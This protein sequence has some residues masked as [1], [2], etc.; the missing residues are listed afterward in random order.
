M[1]APIPK[2]LLYAAL[3]INAII[4]F[5]LS[6]T[7][8]AS[9]YILS[10]LGGNKDI[11]SYTTSFFALGNA[12][13]IPL[14][15]HF[16]RSAGMKTAIKGALFFL[17][18]ISFLLAR[19]P[20]Y[21]IFLLL[22]FFQGCAAGPLL[23]LVPSVLTT[24][25]D[26]RKKNFFIR[27]TTVIYVATSIVAACI[28]GSIAYEWDWRWIF[29]LDVIL[30]GALTAYFLYQ[31][32]KVQF[33]SPHKPIDYLG[34]FF[35][36]VGVLS[37]SLFCILGQQ[38]D[39][40]R[41]YR[42]CFVFPIGVISLIYFFLHSYN[43]PYPIVKVK[44]LFKKDVIFVIV[45]TAMLFSAYFG[46]VFLLSIWLNQYVRYTPN[47]ITLVLGIMAVT[48][49]GVM[50]VMHKL[51]EEHL[52]PTLM[53]AIFFL[54]YSCYLTMNYDAEVDF[55]RL[56]FARI[57][58]GVGLAL[59]FP[60][61]FHLMLN[62]CSSSEGMQGLALFQMTRTLSSGL[63]ISIYATIWQRREAFYHD[64]LGGALTE[65]SEKTTLFLDNLNKFSLTDSMKLAELD[66]ALEE[67]AQ[68]LALNDTFY[69]MYYIMIILAIWALAVYVTQWRQ[70]KEVTKA[71]SLQKST[72]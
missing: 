16:A 62:N 71:I 11:A 14:G 54:A 23:M 68:S 59:F 64:R 32:G 66:A 49:I 33:P 35:F 72:G 52:L 60:P 17:I 61:L 44:L 9:L 51:Q 24:L 13:A 48:S 53:I 40:F 39:W 22:R 34:Y 21:P 41:S 4:I 55:K 67:Q 6:V 65:F 26:E 7:N 69:L 18:G 19:A 37:L 1:D 25:S 56:A 30:T 42:L 31:V 46:T 28:G 2:S 8:M 57:I 45:E 15:L 20:N 70:P 27:N 43:H 36:F 50:L 5:S 47:W 10:D 63:G 38:L 3:S 12:L 58:S 29:H